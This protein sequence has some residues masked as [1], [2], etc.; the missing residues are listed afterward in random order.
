[1]VF[2]RVTGQVVALEDYVSGPI[3][4][5]A[6]TITEPSFVLRT[7][8]VIEFFTAQTGSINSVRQSVSLTKLLH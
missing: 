3:V 1:M 8:D 5:V 4:D 6:G 7:P 2:S